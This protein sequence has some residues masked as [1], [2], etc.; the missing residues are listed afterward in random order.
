MLRCT[1][2]IL[3]PEY[4]YAIF[5]NELFNVQID[6]YSSGAIMSGV[7]SSDFK[8]MLIPIIKNKLVVDKITNNIRNHFNKLSLSNSLIQEAKQDVEDLIEGN[9]DMSKLSDTTPESR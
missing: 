8:K 2:S 3:T 9:F 7:I 4:L 6:K 1:S 5:S